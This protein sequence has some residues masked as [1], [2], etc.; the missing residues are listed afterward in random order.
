MN[1]SVK[2]RKGNVS[3]L[4][5][6][7]SAEKIVLSHVYKR[8]FFVLIKRWRDWAPPEGEEMRFQGDSL[9]IKDPED[10]ARDISV[11]QNEDETFTVCLCA[12]S[13][14][15]YRECLTFRYSRILIDQGEVFEDRW[16]LIERTDEGKAYH[17]IEPE[18]NYVIKDGRA[19][20]AE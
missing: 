13:F 18:K 4:Y 20:L 9:R 2:K 10:P 17:Y 14:D 3:S 19:C 7:N 15:P 6:Q 12:D 1:I 8:K 5:L 11:Y 16:E